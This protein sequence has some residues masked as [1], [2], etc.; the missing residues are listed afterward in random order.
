MRL[1][2]TWYQWY[3]MIIS[4]DIKKKNRIKWPVQI[5]AISI[6]QLPKQGQTSRCP[7]VQ[8]CVSV[9]AALMQWNW[10]RR[11]STM[12]ELAWDFCR[13]W[14]DGHWWWRWRLV[15]DIRSYKIIL[16]DYNRFYMFLITISSG[17]SSNSGDE[18][19]VWVGECLE[20]WSWGHLWD[21]ATMAQQGV[22]GQQP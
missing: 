19:S 3:L 9:A 13:R 10:A 16:S 8:A 18:S 5:C 14:V 22:L 17:I 20:S 4:H 15:K 21:G 2:D 11:P 1:H 6:H 12:L 7:D